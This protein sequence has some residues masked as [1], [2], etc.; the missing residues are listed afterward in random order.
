MCDKCVSFLIILFQ[1][2]LSQ[3]NCFSPRLSKG[4]PQSGIF[5]ISKDYKNCQGCR[6]QWGSET[7]SPVLWGL[8]IRTFLCSDL[9]WF[10]FPTIRTKAIALAKL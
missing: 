1:M 4:L 5:D 3:R 7:K 10:C 9:E 2:S 8:E 6:L